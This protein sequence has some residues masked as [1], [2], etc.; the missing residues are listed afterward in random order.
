M[1]WTKY[2]IGSYFLFY[3]RELAQLMLISWC[4][5][6]SL[7]YG[8]LLLVTNSFRSIKLMHPL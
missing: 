6:L 4:I 2:F 1:D 5:T 3:C 7:G 8:G